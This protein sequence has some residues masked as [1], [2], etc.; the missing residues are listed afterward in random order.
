M[1]PEEEQRG[2]LWTEQ[3]EEDLTRRPLQE[4]PSFLREEQGG[5]E[6]IVDETGME[7]M[8]GETES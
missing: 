1:Q 2:L 5:E 7:E 8:E 3:K 4:V 6:E